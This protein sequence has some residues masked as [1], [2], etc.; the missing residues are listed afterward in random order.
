MFTEDM[1]KEKTSG[2]FV[3]FTD[4][5]IHLFH[6]PQFLLNTYNNHTSGAWVGRGSS[7]NAVLTELGHR[8]VAAGGC[9]SYL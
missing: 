4:N 8:Q 6:R 3:T 2:A 5:N 9:R 1:N 7:W